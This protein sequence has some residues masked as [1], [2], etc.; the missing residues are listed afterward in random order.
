MVLGAYGISGG[1]HAKPEHGV[2]GGEGPKEEGKP[3]LIEVHT[4]AAIF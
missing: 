1:Y 4:T 2:T 3:V